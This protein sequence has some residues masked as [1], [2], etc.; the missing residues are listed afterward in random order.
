MQSS[1]NFIEGCRIWAK[2]HLDSLPHDQRHANAVA[3]IYENIPKEVERVVREGKVEATLEEKVVGIVE[4]IGRSLTKQGV[5][6][7]TVGEVGAMLRL[8]L[9]KAKGMV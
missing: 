4:E 2:S 8:A 1:G 7:L 9:E 6:G 5:K 3:V